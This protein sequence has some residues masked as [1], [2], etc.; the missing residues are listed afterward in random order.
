MPGQRG[1]AGER[2]EGGGG[3]GQAAHHHHR[4]ES[5]G[6]DRPR[7]RT[8]RVLLLLLLGVL[9]LGVLSLARRRSEASSRPSR[10]RRGTGLPGSFDC[11]V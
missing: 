9:L 10:D 6:L 11:V 3:R 1:D 7:S 5:P 8:D 2:Q 4:C